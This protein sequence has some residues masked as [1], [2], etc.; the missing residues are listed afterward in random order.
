MD[1]AAK[2]LRP[3]KVI[4][5]GKSGVGK[6][7]L[8][9]TFFEQPYDETQPTLAPAFCSASVALPD[10]SRVELHVWDTAGQEQ[11]QAVGELF[12]RDSDVAFVCFDFER[13]GTIAEWIRRVHAQVPECIVFL[14]LTKADLL[15]SAQQTEAFAKRTWLIEEHKAKELHITSAAQ[16]SGVNELFLAAGM[17]IKQ[18]CKPA[19][20]VSVSIVSSGKKSD[21]KDKCKC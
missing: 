1:Q 12:Y 5:V 3:L 17:C 4:L 15:T 2:G 9:N 13:M 21:K 10:G 18:I 7:S 16:G 14:V 19:P 8:I 6:T 20:P 11:F